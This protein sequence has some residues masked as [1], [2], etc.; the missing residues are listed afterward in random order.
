MRSSFSKILAGIILVLILLFLATAIAC[1]IWIYLIVF[2]GWF[3]LCDEKLDEASSSSEFLWPSVV[4]VIPARDEAKTIG[5]VVKSHLETDY[6]GSFTLIVVDDQ[7]TDGTREIVAKVAAGANRHVYVVSTKSLPE[8]WQ[9]KLWAVNVGLRAADKAVPEAS[10]VLLTDADIVHAPGT[11]KKLVFKALMDRRSL[12]SVMA[13]LDS[14]EFWGSLLMPAFIF[15][16]QKLY[17]FRSTNDSNST[18]A[19]AAGGCMLVER[20]ALRE[21]GGIEVIRGTLIDDCALAAALKDTKRAKR[22]IWLGFDKDVVSLRD[23][24]DLEGI[25]KMVVRTA[26]TQLKFSNLALVGAAIGMFL[27]YLI[28][29]IAVITAP[30]H[31]SMAVL[32][33]GLFAWVTAMVAYYP[34]LDHYQKSPLWML[35]LPVSAAFYLAMTVS[36]AI[37]H[38]RGRGGAW[39]G[40]TYS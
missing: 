27:A 17:P 39:K 20:N 29:P 15:F 18:V 22:S 33:L 12:V 10:H 3:W 1:A 14:R 25:W 5:T 32:T 34:T 36:S 40:R 31:Q 6:P 35:L 9:G 30:M 19:G 38:W 11:L 2:N 4:A 37:N 21:I 26:F 8:G 16:F 13:H 28:A 23:N 7:S 24:R